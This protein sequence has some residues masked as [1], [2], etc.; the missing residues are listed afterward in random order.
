[1]AVDQVGDFEQRHLPLGDLEPPGSGVLDLWL[2][3]IDTAEMSVTVAAGRNTKIKRRRFAQRFYT[4]LLLAAYVRKAP[5]KLEFCY[6]AQG[7]PL[8]EP[9]DNPTIHFNVSHSRN[10]LAITVS[11]EQMLG[12]DIESNRINNDPLALA[13][14]YFSVAEIKWLKAS[15]DIQT[16]F[17][18]LWVRKEAALKCLGLGIAG[19]LSKTHCSLIESATVDQVGLEDLPSGYR[20]IDKL[21]IID[22]Q[23]KENEILG[24]IALATRPDTV[25][26]FQLV[27][28]R[29]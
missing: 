21:E 18:R 12:V 27:C 10:W 19:K 11:S 5:A 24:A 2:I 13:K 6:S 3:D 22:W 4:R 23:S 1:M 8:L 20:D 16:A 28:T 26:S 14:R 25:R 7:K 15:D 17:N 9:L 29:K